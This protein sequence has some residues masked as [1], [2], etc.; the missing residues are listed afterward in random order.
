MTSMEGFDDYVGASLKRWLPNLISMLPRPS[1]N[2]PDG[3]LCLLL[4]QIGLGLVL[5]LWVLGFKQL[6][7]D[8]RRRHGAGL[9]GGCR[10]PRQAQFPG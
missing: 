3:R 6:L 8:M 4:G 10:S 2:L 1:A 5:P 9:P 7:R